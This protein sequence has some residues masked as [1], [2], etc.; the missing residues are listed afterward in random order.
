MRFDVFLILLPNIL[1]YKTLFTCWATYNK[2]M[3]PLTSPIP[4]FLIS[5]MK[6]LDYIFYSPSGSENPQLTKEKY[7]YI[8]I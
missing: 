7:I 6:G 8:Y 5:K 2:I 4:D 1:V 3:S